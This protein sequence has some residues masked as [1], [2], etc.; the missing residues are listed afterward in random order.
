MLAFTWIIVQASAAHVRPVQFISI[1]LRSKVLYLRR[2]RM[3]AIYDG[4]SDIVHAKSCAQVCMCM[5]MC[6]VHC[7]LCMCMCMYMCLCICVCVIALC[8]GA[9][10]SLGTGYTD[11]IACKPLFTVSWTCWI[12]IIQH[13]APAAQC[14]TH[15]DLYDDHSAE[16]AAQVGLCPFFFRNWLMSSQQVPEDSEFFFRART[17]HLGFRRNFSSRC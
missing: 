11:K 15:R 3:T 6:I 16:M 1:H 9:Q 4:I 8:M 13:E 12:R 2:H 10:D 17:A 14:S 5:C 7:A